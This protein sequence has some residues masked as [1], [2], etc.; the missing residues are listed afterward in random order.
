[1]AF[2]TTPGTF[3]LALSWMTWVSGD[4]ALLIKV[5]SSFVAHQQ[6]SVAQAVRNAAPQASVCMHAD[7]DDQDEVWAR[8]QRQG[9]K[10]D[11]I[12]SCPN[13]MTTV[14]LDCQQHD[15]MANQYR[16]MFVRNCR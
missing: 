7:L 11:A 3:D 9:R 10:S 16:A 15:Y 2:Q 6:Y 14:C 5:T 4:T 8:K 13:C 1:M 12:L